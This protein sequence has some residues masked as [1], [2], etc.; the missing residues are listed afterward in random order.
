MSFND[1]R[2]LGGHYRR[3][4]KGMISAYQKQKVTRDRRTLDRKAF[5]IAKERLI[6]TEGKDGVT[7]S[8]IRYLKK[9]ILNQLK[10]NE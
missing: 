4:H 2:K 6:E 9:R 7:N 3:F 5:Q 8:K 10:K 1:F